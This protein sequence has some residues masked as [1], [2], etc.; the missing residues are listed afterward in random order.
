MQ[1]LRGSRGLCAG[2]RPRAP[3]PP[4]RDVGLPLGRGLLPEPPRQVLC[5]NHATSSHTPHDP[6]LRGRSGRRGREVGLERS[7]ICRRRRTGGKPRQLR[8]GP[9]SRACFGA[10]PPRRTAGQIAVV[11]GEL[12]QGRR[13][14]LASAN[15][16]CKADHVH[17]H[18]LVSV[19]AAA[20]PYAVSGPPLLVGQSGE[21]RAEPSV[22]SGSPREISCVT[23]R[24]SA[25]RRRALGRKAASDHDCSKH[26]KD[27]GTDEGCIHD[28][29]H[30][31]PRHRRTR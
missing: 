26:G 3:R 11:S 23:V 31:C 20:W 12:T 13:R 24:H 21:V 18:G 7:V 22:I 8:V 28:K 9:R 5:S 10:R 17:S 2:S 6:R 30:R 27:E 14:L 15:P 19:Y 1:L 29:P 4:I 25:H 16:A